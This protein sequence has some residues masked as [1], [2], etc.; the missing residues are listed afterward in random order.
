MRYKKKIFTLIV[1]IIVITCIFY[2][3]NQER[4]NINKK[5]VQKFNKDKKINYIYNFALSNIK[6]RTIKF[7]NNIVYIGENQKEI[8]NGFYDI[9]IYEEKENIYIEI[10]KLWKSINEIGDINEKY[11]YEILSAVNIYNL[12]NTSLKD[13]KQLIQKN[14]LI[15][16]NNNRKDCLQSRQNICGVDIEMLCKNKSFTIKLKGVE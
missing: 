10:T 16:L 5:E 4:I 3:L 7:I 1:L 2:A 11:L 12:N 9:A 6:D 8:E 15:Y 13:I 14:Y